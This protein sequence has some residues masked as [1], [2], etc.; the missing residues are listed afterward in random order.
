[1]NTFQVMSIL[2]SKGIISTLNYNDFNPK[3]IFY[4]FKAILIPKTINEADNLYCF[5][6]YEI[7][8]CNK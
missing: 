6:S 3:I 2:L 4:T 8:Q 7:Y 1:M 5:E